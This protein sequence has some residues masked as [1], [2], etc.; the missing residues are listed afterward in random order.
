[1]LI[2]SISPPHLLIE[3]PALPPTEIKQIPGGGYMELT[4][5]PSGLQMSRLC[6]TDPS[7]YLQSKYAIGSFHAEH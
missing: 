7:L 4:R 2:H 5:T 3:Q 1:M 6:A